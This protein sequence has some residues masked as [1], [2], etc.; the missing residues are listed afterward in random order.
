ML[1]ETGRKYGNVI[2]ETKMA[3]NGNI[4][5]FQCFELD[6]VSWEFK[7]GPLPNKTYSFTNVDSYSNT[8]IILVDD[9]SYGQYIC[10]GI[11]YD[12]GMAFYVVATLQPCKLTIELEAIIHWS[13]FIQ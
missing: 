2:P 13:S 10:E 6:E 8:L 12:V 1:F 7:T 11:N 4:A 9:Y 5:V 3:K